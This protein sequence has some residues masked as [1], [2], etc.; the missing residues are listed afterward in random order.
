MQRA[1]EGLRSLTV[2]TSVRG[3]Q[4]T[5]SI[6]LLWHL[7]LT[8]LSNVPNRGVLWERLLNSGGVGSVLWQDAMPGSAE[9]DGTEAVLCQRDIVLQEKR[10]PATRVARQA[11][12]LALAPWR[13]R[14][15]SLTL[16]FLIPKGAVSLSLRGYC[17]NVEQ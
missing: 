16:N 1:R 7:F 11:C 9:A 15:A 10:N 14:W 4:P 3:L 2:A 13:R 5:V 8:I 17:E 6:H 12:R